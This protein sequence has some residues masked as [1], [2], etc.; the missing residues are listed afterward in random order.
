M[1]I[2]TSH[3]MFMHHEE[4]KQDIVEMLYQAALNGEKDVMITTEDAYT[5][6]E[7]EEIEEEVRKRLGI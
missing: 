1:F 7:W 4:E 2:K 5:E 6:R 3:W